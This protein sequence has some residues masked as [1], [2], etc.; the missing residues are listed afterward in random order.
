MRTDTFYPKKF[1][2]TPLDKDGK[3]KGST[4]TISNE[5]RMRIHPRFNEITV[6]NPVTVTWK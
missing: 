6:G 2:V 4:V 1:K 5:R 3:P